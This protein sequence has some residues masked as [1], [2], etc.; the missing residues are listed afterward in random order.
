M[1]K[2]PS[3]FIRDKK[4]PKLV[5]TEP[6]P[7]AQ[8]VFDGEGVATRKWDGTACLIRD[9]VYYKRLRHKAENGEPPA[10]WIHWSFDPEQRSGHGWVPVGDGP[11]D[12][13]HREAETAGLPGGTY[14]LCGP[15]INQ[16]PERLGSVRLI[17]HGDWKA[18]GAPRTRE[19]LGDW[20][21]GQD[22]EGLVWHHPDGRM[23]K[24]KKK[25]LGLSRKD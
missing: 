10:R 24:I 5:T 17:R 11:Q 4:N 9:G 18:V 20:L 13:I 1:Q 16:N 25:D 6:E 23:A 22:I 12:A 15:R 7:E 3:I 2:I 14:E 21:K 19:G 8:W